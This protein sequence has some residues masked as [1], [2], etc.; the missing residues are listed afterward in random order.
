MISY[1]TATTSKKEN[2]YFGGSPEHRHGRKYMR[3]KQ[4][5]LRQ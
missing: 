3:A 4:S 2:N 5:F 1:L